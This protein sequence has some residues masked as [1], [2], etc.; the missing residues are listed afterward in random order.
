MKV[1]K[2][3]G[4][5]NNFLLFDSIDGLLINRDR[6]AF[7]RG[8]VAKKREEGFIPDGFL[9]VLPPE[10]GADLR[11]E[12]WDINRETGEPVIANMCGN[13][14]RCV[15]RY[16][17]DKYRK[18]DMSIITDDGLKYLSVDQ[19]KDIHVNMGPPREFCKINEDMYF[20]NSSLPHVVCLRE[21]L[22]ITNPG[23][24]ETAR[25][26]GK[27][28]RHD[29]S[30]MD[31]LCYNELHVNFARRSGEKEIEIITF[32]AGVENLTMACGTGATASAYVISEVYGLG[33]PIKVMNRGGQLKVDK[34]GL[35]LY[36]IGPAVYIK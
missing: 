8:E 18:K 28:I 25:I 11:M 21:R 14:I 26:D 32:E 30:L 16:V 4:C 22:D 20:V 6:K 24:V 31:R 27:R 35:D 33:Y 13:G 2:M 19:K 12:Y 9:F 29:K 15:G 36:L 10:N 3:S 23:H 17:Y 1:K 7:A 5:G 34:R